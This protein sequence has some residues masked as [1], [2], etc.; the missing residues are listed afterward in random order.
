MVWVRGHG[1]IYLPGEV[2]MKMKTASV[3]QTQ[4]FKKDL[5]PKIQGICKE[6][7][8]ERR[9][10]DKKDELPDADYRH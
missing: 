7:R 2:L 6:E 1:H 9:K 4:S 5:Q 8:K 3:R 10:N